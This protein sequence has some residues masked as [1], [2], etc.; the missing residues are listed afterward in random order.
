M[1][2]VLSSQNPTS[3][4][5]M[6]ERLPRTA[7]SSPRSGQHGAPPPCLFDFATCRRSKCYCLSRQ[8]SRPEIWWLDFRERH[9]LPALRIAPQGIARAYLFQDRAVALMTGD[10]GQDHPQI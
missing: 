3:G 5:R 1:E 2:G 10:V 7:G 4:V 8:V 6:S 9:D